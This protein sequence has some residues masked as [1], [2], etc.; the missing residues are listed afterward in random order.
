[1]DSWLP[2]E[3]TDE[4]DVDLV[5]LVSSSLEYDIDKT[6]A[7]VVAL[8]T[9]VNDHNAASKVNDVLLGVE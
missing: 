3:L 5:S 2:S 4:K 7:F 9:D 8:L 1:M 6:R